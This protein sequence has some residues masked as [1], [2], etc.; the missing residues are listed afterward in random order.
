[1]F[2]CEKGEKK[3]ETNPS[4]PLLFPASQPRNNSLEERGKKR[5][6]KPYL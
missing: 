2:K 4:H 1:V 6:P 5:K 3:E